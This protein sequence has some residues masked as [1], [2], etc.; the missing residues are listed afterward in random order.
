VESKK[1][2]IHTVQF[3][4][5]GFERSRRTFFL[6]PLYAFLKESGE[7]GLVDFFEFATKSPLILEFG[8]RA[9]NKAGERIESLYAFALLL[10]LCRDSE[11]DKGW[12]CFRYLG[13]KLFTFCDHG[14]NLFFGQSAPALIRDCDAL[15]IAPG[16]HLIWPTDARN[17]DSRPLVNCANSSRKR[18]ISGCV[19]KS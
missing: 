6:D 12:K 15:R 1:N 3:L 17:P 4:L 2:K 10:I 5:E 13:R 18:Q 14:L 7:F 19:V 16:R 11:D 8:P 9:V